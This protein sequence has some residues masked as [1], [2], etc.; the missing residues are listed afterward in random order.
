MF[1][2]NIYFFFPA[3]K[4]GGVAPPVV[5]PVGG[6]RKQPKR[7]QFTFPNGITVWA[8][9]ES[10]ARAL[11]GVDRLP[12]E[13]VEIAAADEDVRGRG[14]N[15]AYPSGIEPLSLATSLPA[16]AVIP[17][18]AVAVVQ[19]DGTLLAATREILRLRAEEEIIILH[20]L[21]DEAA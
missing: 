11:S 8:T 14:S 6:T 1:T 17:P 5:V 20:L 12:P 16:R 4:S 10:Y 15:P 21:M 9:D 7:R 2:A 3:L 18:S 19:D 13:P